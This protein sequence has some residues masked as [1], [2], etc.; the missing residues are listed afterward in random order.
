MAFHASSCLDLFIYEESGFR[1][2]QRP[3]MFQSW[4]ELLSA[5][6]N[7]AAGVFMFIAIGYVGKTLYQVGHRLVS[8]LWK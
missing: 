3:G 5:V 2:N 6:T 7:M 8:G 1:M 4:F